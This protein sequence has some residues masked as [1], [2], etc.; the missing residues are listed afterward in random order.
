MKQTH[1]A[2]RCVLQG[3]GR[4]RGGGNFGRESRPK[5]DLRPAISALIPRAVQFYR[6]EFRQCPIAQLEAYVCLPFLS[7]RL[8]VQKPTYLT[9]AM[10]GRRT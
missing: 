3:G 1:I 8:L 5:R 4:G 6:G 10:G 7:K 9:H 2:F